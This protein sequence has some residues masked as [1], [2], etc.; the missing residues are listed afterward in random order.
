M[1]DTGDC[2]EIG[3]MLNPDTGTDMAYEELWRILPIEGEEV[4]LIESVGPRNKMFL[5]RIGKW[6]QGIGTM[7][8][9]VHAKRSELVNGQWE[10]VFVMGDAKMVPVIQAQYMEWKE[11]DEVN[12]DGRAWTVLD[13]ALL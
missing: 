7:E 11:G 4:V 12:I 2:L 9:E 8:G 6:F 10:D 3:T 5:G 13:C 1:L